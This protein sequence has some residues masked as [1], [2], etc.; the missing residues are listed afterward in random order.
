MRPLAKG[1][2]KKCAAVAIDFLPDDIS[3]GGIRPG[4]CNFLASK[5]PPEFAVQTTGHELKVAP[6]LNPIRNPDRARPN[7]G[8][9]L[10][11][12]VA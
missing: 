12:I 9:D 1:G 11:L 8:L 3:A 7:P 6:S 4:V 5:M 10:T 2:S